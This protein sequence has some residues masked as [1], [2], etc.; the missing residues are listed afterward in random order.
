[1]PQK[2]IVLSL[3]VSGN[4]PTQMPPVCGLRDGKEEIRFLH[5]AAVLELWSPYKEVETGRAREMTQRS[6]CVP[7]KCE[8]CSSDPSTH[9]NAKWA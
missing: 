7:Y 2:Q 1:M 9:L 4:L 5:L 6:K 8:D 3:Q